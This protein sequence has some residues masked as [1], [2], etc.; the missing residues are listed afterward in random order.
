M[1]LKRGAHLAYCTNIHPG[2][3]WAQTF[4]SLRNYTL[5]VRDRVCRDQPFAIGLR[6]SDEASRELINPDMLRDFRGWLAA[7]NCYV[8]T[9]NGFPFGRFHGGRVKEAGFGAG[10]RLA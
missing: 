9:I 6:L 2:E 4:A 1:Q 7:E 3:N 5:A 10:R 8:F